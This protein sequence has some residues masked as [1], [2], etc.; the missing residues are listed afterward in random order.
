MNTRFRDHAPAPG[1]EPASDPEAAG[2][3]LLGPLR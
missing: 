2:D 3:R 1:P